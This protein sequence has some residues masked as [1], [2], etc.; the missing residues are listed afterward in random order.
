MAAFGI[1][2]LSCA[3]ADPRAHALSWRGLI[4][5]SQPAPSRC[6]GVATY[7]EAVSPLDA[8]ER[9]RWRAHAGEELRVARHNAGGGFYHV[10]VLH[11]EQAAQCALKALLRGIGRT[12]RARGHDLLRL[13]DEA[14]AHAPL[15]LDDAARQRLSMLA[16]DYQPSRYP[17]ALPGGTPSGHYGA[18]D[19]ERAVATAEDVLEAAD[20]AWAAVLS[21]A[22]EVDGADAS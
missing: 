8:F 6:E 3:A 13:A 22:E 2:E 1:A 18:A 9:D 16:R 19:A 10:A 12:E 21:A 5:L 14:V 15:E 20:V 7:D 11:A 17:D 4:G